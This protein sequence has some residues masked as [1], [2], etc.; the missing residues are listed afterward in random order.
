ML[1]TVESFLTAPPQAIISLVK[2]KK[3]PLLGVF[4]PDGSRRLVLSFTDAK[5]STS[6]FYERCATLPAQHLLS[7]INTFFVHGLETLLVPILSRSVINRG[8]AY[9]RLTALT[10]LRLLFTSREWLGFYAKNKIRVRTYGDLDYLIGTECEPAISWIKDVCQNTSK[11][12]NHTLYFAIGES[13]TLGNDVAAMGI[14]FYK[15]NG[16]VPTP[17]EQIRQ[18]YG[19][20]LPMADFFIMTSKM[21]GMGALPRFLINGDTE[22]YFLPAAGATGLNQT[23]YRLILHDMLFERSALLK[24]YA[25]NAISDQDRTALKTYYKQN[26]QTV[27]GLGKQIGGIWVPN[28]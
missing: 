25:Q 23:T 11:F 10:G 13:P 8:N 14:S 19:Q 18:Y 6:E 1:N 26:S 7:S 21:S 9:Q 2:E 20:N 22:L 5:P 4:V 17:Q 24:N 15:E 3:R 12:E 27:I 28:V 16:R